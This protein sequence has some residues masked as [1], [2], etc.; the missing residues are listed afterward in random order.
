MF[1]TYT[2][3]LRWNTMRWY[4]RHWRK[5]QLTRVSS[6]GQQKTLSI[7]IHSWMTVQISWKLILKLYVKWYAFWHH[8][9]NIYSITIEITCTIVDVYSLLRGFTTVPFNWVVGKFQKLKFRWKVRDTF[10]LLFDG[11]FLPYSFVIC[12]ERNPL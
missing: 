8:Y 10:S 7:S 9:D 5:I 12:V 4:Q 2:K 6:W 1:S 11:R 3:L